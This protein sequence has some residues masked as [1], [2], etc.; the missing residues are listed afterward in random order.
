MTDPT[1]VAAKEVSK[2]QHLLQQAAKAAGI[3]QEEIRRQWAQRDRANLERVLKE[4]AV[5]S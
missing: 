3:S 2:F 4:I 5:H 1:D